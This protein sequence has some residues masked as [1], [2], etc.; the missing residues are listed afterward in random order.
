MPV[1][2]QPFPHRGKAAIVKVVRSPLTERLGF[3]FQRQKYEFVHSHEL[4]ES[5]PYASEL[6]DSG[7]NNG[8]CRLI[9]SPVDLPVMHYLSTTGIT[10][11]SQVDKS[12][13]QFGQNRLAVK[14]ATFLEMYKEQLLS[15]I[16]MFQ[17]FCSVLWMLDEYWQYTMFT[18]FSIALIE[19]GTVFQRQRTLATLSGMRFNQ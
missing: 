15:P 17:F 8:C 5:D 1:W 6:V 13:E 16:A 18:L 10:S 4:K 19:S 3:E 11:K 7:R 2:S 9:R 14:H 12:L